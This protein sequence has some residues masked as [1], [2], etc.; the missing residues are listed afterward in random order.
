MKN[1]EQS[2]EKVIK[3]IAETDILK[4]VLLVLCI[5]LMSGLIFSA[6]VKVGSERTRFTNDWTKSY[7]KNFDGPRGGFIDKWRN[8]GDM[9]RAVP[10]LPMGGPVM[11]SRIDGHGAFGEVISLT[12]K[13]FVIKSVTDVEK[14]ILITDYTFFD[15]GR[16][17]EASTVEVGNH[18]V[19]IGSPNSEGQIE[20]KL[21][22]TFSEF[23]YIK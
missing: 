5:V 13:S 21:I 3:E 8:N 14:V 2:L 10:R 18:V 9:H 1:L 4:Y 17:L 6:G 20:A 19:V 15:A 12:K 7:H 23:N 22:R 16:G 11:D